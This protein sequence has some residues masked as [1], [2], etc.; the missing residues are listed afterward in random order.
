[1]SILFNSKQNAGVLPV[2]AALLITLF[3]SPV[4]G[5]AQGVYTTAGQAPDMVGSDIA[6]MVG[7]L[8]YNALLALLA[9]VVLMGVILI[10]HVSKACA[11]LNRPQEN[12]RRR[13][14]TLLILVAALS[15]FCGSC[16]AEQRAMATQYRDVA[17]AENGTCAMPYHSEKHSNIPYTDGYPSYGYFNL[18]SPT[19]CKYC[20]QRIFKSR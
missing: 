7:Q 20:G 12:P 4:A 14:T 16:T 13:F 9:A 3:F 19:F 5:K 1:M 15:V 2:L 17:A 11:D 8:E 10:C 6:N 18:D